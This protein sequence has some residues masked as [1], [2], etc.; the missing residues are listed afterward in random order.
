MTD[1]HET[2]PQASAGAV[3]WQTFASHWSS[4]GPPLRPVDTDIQLID[5]LLKEQL[6]KGTAVPRSSPADILVLGVTPEYYHFFSAQGDRVRALD[7]S[8]QMIASVW[9]GSREDAVEGSWLAMP[10]ADNSF[11]LILCDGG[12]QLLPFPKGLGQ[13]Q[14]ELLRCLRPG[15]RFCVRLFARPAEPLSIRSVLDQVVDGRLNNLHALKILAG[16]GLQETT[17]QG[18]VLDAIWHSLQQR[19][20]DWGQLAGLLAMDA[21]EVAMLDA[22]R[23]NSA[24][25]HFLSEAEVIDVFSQQKDGFGLEHSVTRYPDYRYGEFCPTLLFEKQAG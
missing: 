25:Y 10:Y 2:Q 8:P 23:G 9:P 6:L 22:Y 11:D 24:V 21:R 14:Q 13:L 18:V 17:E 15:G 5:Q 19:F 20:S 1:Q 4:L 3:H 7:K 12:L 16:M